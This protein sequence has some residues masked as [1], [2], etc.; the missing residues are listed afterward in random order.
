MAD[1]RSDWQYCLLHIN[2]DM[3]GLH[4]DSIR[5]NLGGRQILND[6]FI[7]CQKGEIIGLLGRNGS[8]KSTLL[9]VIFGSLKADHKYVAIDGL[10]VDTLFEARKYIQYLPQDNFLPSHLR[11]KNIISCFCTPQKAELFKAEPVIQTLLYK[12]IGELSGG[13]KRIFEVLL[14]LHS[15]ADYLL[16]DEPFNGISP[17]QIEIIKELIQIHAVGKGVIITDHSYENVLAIASKIIL[18]N[19]GN[20]R[21][22][23]GRHELVDYGYLPPL[24]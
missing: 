18:L 22:I 13:E 1:H 2:S 9:Q 8:G 11:L 16:F 15:A 23:N 19:N 7:S 5:K 12:K 24:S 3:N 4:A 10:R 21:L 14:L 6:I 17:L 20:T